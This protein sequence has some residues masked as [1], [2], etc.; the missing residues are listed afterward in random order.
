MSL[1]GFGDWNLNL[2]RGLLR[3]C[4]FA[5]AVW[6]C[7]WLGYVWVTRSTLDP[8]H[9]YYYTT[10]FNEWQSSGPLSFGNCVGIF[11]TGISVP[12]AMLILGIGVFW[13]VAGFK[14]PR[15]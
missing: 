12:I 4:I 14:G 2:R 15:V 8:E 7:G 6:F 10:P 13:V 3:A 9:V 11:V 5:S 1:R